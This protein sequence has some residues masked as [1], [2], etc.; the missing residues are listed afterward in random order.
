VITLRSGCPNQRLAGDAAGSLL[1][2]G[3][4]R[5]K[6][7]DKIVFVGQD[8]NMGRRFQVSSGTTRRSCSAQQ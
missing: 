4:V 1:L 3:A 5:P 8:A 7:P 2:G 6:K